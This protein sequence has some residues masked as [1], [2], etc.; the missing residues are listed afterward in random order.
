MVLAAL[1]LGARIKR[2]DHFD[3]EQMLAIR[4][5]PG[6]RERGL[7]DYP[8]RFSPLVV[9]ECRGCQV[10]LRKLYEQNHLK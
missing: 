4:T 7:F 10:D 1:Q 3:P 5:L 9:L 6:A 8:H 2:I